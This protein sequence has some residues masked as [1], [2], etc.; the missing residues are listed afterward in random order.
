MVGFKIARLVKVYSYLDSIILYSMNSII[1]TLLIFYNKQ[2]NKKSAGKEA[3]AHN[4]KN[5]KYLATSNPSGS[6]TG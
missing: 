1:V 4:H 2:I 5:L 3:A 6:S